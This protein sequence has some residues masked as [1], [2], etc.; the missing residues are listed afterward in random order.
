MKRK[1]WADVVYVFVILIALGVIVYFAKNHNTINQ[2]VKTE[3]CRFG[4]ITLDMDSLT[5]VEHL[6]VQR[7]VLEKKV[8]KTIP[9]VVNNDSIGYTYTNKD[10]LKEEFYIKLNNSKVCQIYFMSS[11]LTKKDVCVNANYRYINLT[12]EPLKYSCE[13]FIFEHDGKKMYRVTKK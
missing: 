8:C 10:S 9:L 6:N 3:E 1:F 12:D 13:T 11:F 4:N 2:T 7:N 5:A